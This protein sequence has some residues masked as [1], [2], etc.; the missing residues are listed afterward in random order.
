MKREF[1]YRMDKPWRLGLPDQVEGRNATG[2]SVAHGYA[3]G[4]SMVGG[5]IRSSIAFRGLTAGRPRLI[6]GVHLVSVLL[7]VLG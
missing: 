3:G 6:T 5:V 4:G 2:H 7:R 1:T